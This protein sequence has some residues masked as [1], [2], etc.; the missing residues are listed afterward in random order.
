MNDDAYY[1]ERAEQAACGATCDRAR[2]GCLIVFPLFGEI[3]RGCNASPASC[4]DA[5][6]L[7]HDGHCCRA[8]HAEINALA[9]AAA[10]E[11]SPQ[12]ATAYVTHYPCISC[13]HALIAHGIRRIVY[14]DHYRP[15]E[16]TRAVLED[17]GVEVKQHGR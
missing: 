8:T 10:R 6:H 17:A 4:E 16:A 12:G 13:A 5:G 14:R 1:M 3:G 11:L 2:V 7:M 9:Q 15:N